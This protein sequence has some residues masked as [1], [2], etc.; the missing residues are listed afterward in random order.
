MIDTDELEVAL[1]AIVTVAVA[2]LTVVP[3][4]R[5]DRITEKARSLVCEALFRIGTVI[6][7]D[8]SLAAKVSVPDVAV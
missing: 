5:L 8:V 1:A 2:L 7:F 4:D 6:V 3:P